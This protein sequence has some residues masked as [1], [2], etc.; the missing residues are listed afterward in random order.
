[1]HQELFNADRKGLRALSQRRTENQKN[2]LHPTV[3]HDLIN[4]GI[5]VVWVTVLTILLVLGGFVCFAFSMPGTTQVLSVVC[6]IYRWAVPYL[7]GY[8][9][10][11]YLYLFNLL[12]TSWHTYHRMDVEVREEL[13]GVGSLLPSWVLEIKLQSSRCQQAPLSLE[14]LSGSKLCFI[15]V[16][17]KLC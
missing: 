15:L 10:F 12:C 17:I 4:Y 1:M 14:P 2:K 6:M 13:L 3:S 9:I 7:Q 5:P 11:T 16:K 8:L